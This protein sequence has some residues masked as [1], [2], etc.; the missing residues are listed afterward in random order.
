MVP[1]EAV[2]LPPDPVTLIEYVT[3]PLVDVGVTDTV[4]F[5]VTDPV[6]LPSVE[7]AIT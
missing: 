2:T 4:P 5:K 6:Q 7:D 3:E 1:D